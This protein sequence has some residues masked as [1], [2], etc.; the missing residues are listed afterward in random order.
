MSRVVVV[1]QVAR[2][3]VLRVENIPE[4]GG[5]V[6]VAERHELLGG[7][8]AN[9]GVACRQL[10]ADVDL[11]GI[12]GD[13]SAARE[14]LAQAARD[15]LGIGGVLRRAGAPTALLL[16]IVGPAGSR[17][18]F[19]D[20]DSRVLLT[21]EDVGASAELFRAADAVLVQLQQPGPAIAAALELASVGGSL[22]VTDGA[23]ADGRTREQVLSS[24]AVVRADSAETEALVGWEPGDLSQTVEA[25]Q[26]VLRKGPRIVA[27]AAPGE[28]NVVAWHG[29]HVVLPFLEE[30]P[31][32]PTGAG[33][34]FIAALTIGLLEGESPEA[35]AWWAAAA[36]AQVVST[37]GGRPNL[38]LEGVRTAAQRA[39]AANR[40]KRQ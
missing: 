39:Q 22:L 1:G 40:S 12:V 27:L 30:A 5:S 29:G 26:E 28:G 4:D 37:V 6:P 23:P 2:D 38:R 35:A 16:D 21:P 9:Q 13:D 25:A 19:E 14:V 3:L 15:G 24:A 11:V 10:G 31:V 18:L 34:A 32:D 36:A 17:R 20:V 33:D 8:G 7:K